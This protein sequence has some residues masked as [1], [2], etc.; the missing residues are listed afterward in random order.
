MSITAGPGRWDPA[1]ALAYV[2]GDRELLA[3]LLAIF[4]T[5]GPAHIQSLRDAITR[6]DA[7]ELTRVAHMLKGELHTLGAVT[8]ASFA[9]RLEEMGSGGGLDGALTLVTSLDGELSRLLA[10]VA[11]EEWQ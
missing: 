9:A 2:G 4:A 8:G 5:D 1:A 11:G 6:A 10:S 7:E 3:E